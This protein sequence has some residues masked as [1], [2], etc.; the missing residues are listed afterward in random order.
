MFVCP[1]SGD[2]R[3]T[4]TQSDPKGM[5]KKCDVGHRGKMSSSVLGF[6]LGCQKGKG[7][8]NEQ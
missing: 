2:F 6:V 7:L 3:I 5:V 8:A 1:P 4:V